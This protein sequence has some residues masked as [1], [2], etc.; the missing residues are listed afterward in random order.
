MEDII[1]RGGGTLLVK[2]YNSDKNG[3]MLQSPVTIF[4]DGR[5][6]EVKAGQRIELKPGESITLPRGQYHSFWAEGGKCLLGEVSQTNDDNHDNRFYESIGRFP[7][8]EN[9]EPILYPLFSEYPNM[10][11]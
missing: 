10:L 9:D 8:I 5:A 3:E 7:Q 6:Y 4:S 1:N 11:K 2:C